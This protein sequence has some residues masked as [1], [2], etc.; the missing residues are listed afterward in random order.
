[1]TC[2]I[3]SSRFLCVGL[4]ALVALSPSLSPAY[5]EEPVSNHIQTSSGTEPW[6][7]WRPETGAA[8][9]IVAAD[10]LRSLSQEFAALT[11]H[12]T[13]NVAPHDSLRRLNQS[14][15]E[16]ARA[17]RALEQSSH[18]DQ[19]AMEA[20]DAETLTEISA[21]KGLW[22]PVQE[23]IAV[24][25]KTPKD[26]AALSMVSAGSEVLFDLSN[27]LFSQVK[28]QY[29]KPA[30][31]LTR[32]AI[33]IDIAGRQAALTQEISGTACRIWAGDRSR[34]RMEEFSSAAWMLERGLISLLHGL[35]SMGIIPA[36]TDEIR[37]ELKVALHEW[38][39]LKVFVV[40]MTESAVP[41]V[42]QR[43]IYERLY[44]EHERLNAIVQ[45]YTDY[46]RHL[47]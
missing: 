27:G 10:R 25:T 33:L 43:L 41:P 29:T 17:L 26:A 36:P 38:R 31:M 22:F 40:G 13:Q 35:P 14:A 30:E 6:T 9:S 45:L 24:V 16:F 46:S 23:A 28:A 2:E 20:P 12:V 1:M 39:S 7:F 47:Y 8:Q 3:V 15:K 44:E 21:V 4:A 11:C 34:K 37:D 5:A 18:P 42:A 19:D 32:D